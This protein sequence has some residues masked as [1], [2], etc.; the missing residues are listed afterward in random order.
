MAAPP[1]DCV[2]ADV[3]LAAGLN[4]ADVS[5][6]DVHGEGKA[7]NGEIIE[8]DEDSVATALL[9][10]PTNGIFRASKEVGFKNSDGR[11]CLWGLNNISIRA[12]PSLGR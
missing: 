12:R 10:P 5:G 3:S 7:L 2:V 4:A 8:A 6:L 1:D 9:R 11:L